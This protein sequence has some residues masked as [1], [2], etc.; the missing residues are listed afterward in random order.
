MRFTA[1]YKM[2]KKYV[3]I[4]T[5][6]S[7]DNTCVFSSDRRGQ[8][9]EGPCNFKFIWLEIIYIAHLFQN[10]TEHTKILSVHHTS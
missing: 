5:P 2:H 10:N 3:S 6:I 9:K 1:E 4:K 8:E 7:N